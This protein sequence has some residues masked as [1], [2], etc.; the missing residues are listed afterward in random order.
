MVIIAHRQ[1]IVKNRDRFA[2]GSR[3]I[4]RN[5]YPSFLFLVVLFAMRS[6]INERSMLKELKSVQTD[7]E[8]VLKG[9]AQV[10]KDV[11]LAKT[12]SLGFF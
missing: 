6:Y 12:E 1:S 9:Q 2:N 8:R 4:F 5:I 3:V 10:L 11:V 7:L